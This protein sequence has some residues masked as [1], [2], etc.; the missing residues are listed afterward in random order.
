MALPQQGVKSVQLV[1]L[2][3]SADCMETIEEI[4]IENREYFMQAG[5]ERYEYIPAL[6]AESNDIVMMAA[7]L[8]QHLQG[9]SGFDDTAQRAEL[10]TKLGAKN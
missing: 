3:F 8:E 1:C 2:G 9:W 4:G 5:G 7:L 10:A 6:N